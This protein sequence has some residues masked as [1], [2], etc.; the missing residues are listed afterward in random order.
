VPN[1]SKYTVRSD[2]IIAGLLF[3]LH[4]KPYLFLKNSKG[5]FK[6]KAKAMPIN[7]GLKIENSLEI[8]EKT[9]SI[10]TIPTMSNML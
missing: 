3:F 8:K 7:S 10:F 6:I 9:K 4:I 2:V 1:S 5:L